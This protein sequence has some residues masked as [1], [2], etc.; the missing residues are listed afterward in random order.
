MTHPDVR[1][2][3]KSMLD[4]N[5]NPYGLTQKQMDE[6][7]VTKAQVAEHLKNVDFTKHI[8]NESLIEVEQKAERILKFS[9]LINP[10]TRRT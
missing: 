6:L 5:Q 10:K 4:R 2:G 1:G 8:Q 3:R 7:E 9:R